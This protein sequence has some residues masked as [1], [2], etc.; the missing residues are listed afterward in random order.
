MLPQRNGEGKVAD[1]D[2]KL[3]H[4]LPSLTALGSGRGTECLGPVDH[5]LFMISDDSH[6]LVF[7]DWLTDQVMNLELAA[8]FQQLWIVGSGKHHGG[9]AVAWVPFGQRLQ[10]IKA[11]TI[12][13]HH[14]E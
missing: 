4:D 7:V 10:Y 9:R 1:R 3:V 12:G 6:E 5:E 14:V 13:K 2:E 8:A 11:A